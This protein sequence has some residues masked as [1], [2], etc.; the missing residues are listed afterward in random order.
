[1]LFSMFLE[2][3]PLSE[4]SVAYSTLKNS[5]TELVHPLSVSFKVVSSREDN[6]TEI[7]ERH[8]V[9]CCVDSAQK[10]TN[11]IFKPALAFIASCR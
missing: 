11:F 5:L 10:T 8:D 7:A 1:M 4:N 6:S 2:C 9:C 3:L